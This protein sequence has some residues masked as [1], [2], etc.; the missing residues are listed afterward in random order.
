MIKRSVFIVALFLASIISFSQT[1]ILGKWENEET[2]ITL[3]IYN[4]I[5]EYSGNII[6]VSN[7][8]SKEK[9]GHLLLNHLVYNKSLKKYSGKV[10]TTSGITASCE[11]EMLNHD[12]FQLTV[13]K[14][15][16]KKKKIFKRTE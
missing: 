8:D 3:E 2:G 4:Q 12:Q 16:I 14:F 7:S 5:N 9:V 6:K 1:S 13:S 10:K 15:L 11:I